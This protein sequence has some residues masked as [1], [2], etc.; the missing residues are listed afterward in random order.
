LAHLYSSHGLPGESYYYRL[1]AS[2]A[3]E[4]KSLTFVT[5]LP[6]H[7][8]T[9]RTVHQPTRASSRLPSIA[10]LAICHLNARW[11]SAKTTLSRS[12]KVSHSKVSHFIHIPMD[13]TSQSA[14]TRVR[15]CGAAAEPPAVSCGA[16]Q[17]QPQT[18]PV[19]VTCVRLVQRSQVDA[20]IC[21]RDST[22]VY[23]EMIV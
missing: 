15:N 12:R 10:A 18:S 14:A 22:R 5:V 8:W 2:A 1:T 3:G 9:F 17:L 7:K 16:R 6:Q 20:R 13:I 11:W 19:M 23:D 21:V 4:S